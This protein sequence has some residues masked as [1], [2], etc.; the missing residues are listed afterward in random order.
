MGVNPYQK[1]KS[2][3]KN[4]DKFNKKKEYLKGILPRYI[5]Y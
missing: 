2:K 3:T 1:K 5:I 4:S